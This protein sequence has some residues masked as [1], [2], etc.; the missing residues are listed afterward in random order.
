MEYFTFPF[1]CVYSY[2]KD[3]FFYISDKLNGIIGRY[4]EEENETGRQSNQTFH[5]CGGNDYVCTYFF[6]FKWFVVYQ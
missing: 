3:I 1:L 6:M 4:M 2:E 5:S